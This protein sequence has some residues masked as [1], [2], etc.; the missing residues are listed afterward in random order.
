MTPEGAGLLESVYFTAQKVGKNR[1][2]AGVRKKN[3]HC[4]TQSVGAPCFVSLGTHSTNT[5]RSVEIRGACGR[6]L[7]LRFRPATLIP[8]GHNAGPNFG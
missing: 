3:R 6:C 8:P 2:L 7:T 1:V 5:R 4:R